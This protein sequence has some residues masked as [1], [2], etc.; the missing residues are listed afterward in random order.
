MPEPSVNIKV[1][2]L[3]DAKT[4]LMKIISCFFVQQQTTAE[5]KLQNL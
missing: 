4:F 1:N 3:F 5:R 2:A